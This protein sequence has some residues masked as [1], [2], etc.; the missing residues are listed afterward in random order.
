MDGGFYVAVALTF[1]STIIIV[2]LLSDK[3][4][5]DALDGRIAV[6]FLIVQDIAVVVA[7]MAISALGA[8][9]DTAAWQVAV[10]LVGR[11][12][13]AG[14]LMFVLMRYVLPG[15]V[16]SMARSQELLRPTAFRCASATARTRTS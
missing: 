3:R 6:G 9:A 7:M 2:K 10:S 13:A 8:D 12:V 14:L 4:E 16:R 1:S 15:V 5:L 11:I